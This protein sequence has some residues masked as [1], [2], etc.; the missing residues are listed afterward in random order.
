MEHGCSMVLEEAYEGIDGWNYAGN[1][2]TQKVLCIGLW[3]PIV[4][5]DAKEYFH[6]YDVCQEVGKPYI[7][8]EM[9]LMPQV[10]LQVFDKWVVD[11][12]GPIHPLERRS[13]D[14]YIITSTKYLTILAEEALVNDC[15]TQTT[16]QFLFENVVTIFGCPI[17]L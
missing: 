11:F 15:N 5:K 9:P 13:R 3:W 17:I 2:T 16:S 1:P 6:T 4:H 8:D 12:I 10:T 7:R 14:R